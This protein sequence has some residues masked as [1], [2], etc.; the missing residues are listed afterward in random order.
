MKI[1]KIR[2]G[3]TNVTLSVGTYNYFL[4]QRINYF[5]PLVFFLKIKLSFMS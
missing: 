3:F 2:D 5:T 4:S 1:F